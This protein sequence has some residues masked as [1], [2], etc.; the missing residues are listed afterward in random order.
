[1]IPVTIKTG[2]ESTQVGLDEHPRADTTMQSLGK[3]R[4]ILVDKDSGATV[5]AGNASGQN[6]GAS[7]CIVASL[8]S[9]RKLGLKPYA[10]ML[11]WSVAG[12]DPARMGI[13][14]VPA[15][16]KVLQRLN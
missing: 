4:S 5:T 2:K 6:D 13:G 16:T 12:V 8:E 1:V 3:L 10:R 14:P 7:A 15:T 11:G 9:A